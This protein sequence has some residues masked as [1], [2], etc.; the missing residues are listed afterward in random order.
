[1]EMSSLHKSQKSS[2]TFY[3][4]SRKQE[5]LRLIGTSAT[6]SNRPTINAQMSVFTFVK[7]SN[8]STFALCDNGMV[9][10]STIYIASL[11]SRRPTEALLVR[12]APRLAHCRWQWATSEVLCQ[13]GSLHEY[14]SDLH[15]RPISYL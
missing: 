7:M 11:N 9:R 5:K 6:V 14:L 12:L 1:L 15:G 2:R 4:A 13:D 8:T 10:Y 3:R